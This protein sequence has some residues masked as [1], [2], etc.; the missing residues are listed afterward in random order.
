MASAEKSSIYYVTEYKYRGKTQTYRTK[1]LTPVHERLRKDH[2]GTTMKCDPSVPWPFG[3]Y[4]EV[5]Q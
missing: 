4:A 1:S 2:Q 5:V 3:V